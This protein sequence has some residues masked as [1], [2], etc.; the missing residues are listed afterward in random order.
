M[1]LLDFSFGQIVSKDDPTEFYKFEIYEQHA[2]NQKRYNTLQKAGGRALFYRLTIR[3]IWVL[4]AQ[5][6]PKRIIESFIRPRRS[7]SRPRLPKA[8]RATTVSR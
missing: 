1:N 4:L 6:T 8:R 5:K 7:R 3:G 2:T